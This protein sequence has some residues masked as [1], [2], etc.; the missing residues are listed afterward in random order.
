MYKKVKFTGGFAKPS[1]PT[2]VIRFLDILA[3]RGRLG[4]CGYRVVRIPV[5]LATIL[6]LLSVSI[7]RAAV[8]VRKN[9]AALTANENTELVDAFLALKA[10]GK[11]DGYVKTHRENYSAAHTTNPASPNPAFLPWHRQFMKQIQ[12]DIKALPG[13]ATTGNPLNQVILPYSFCYYM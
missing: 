1:S 3:M 10:N 2:V 8:D 7:A 11:Y 4:L 6:S 9:V 13:N 5:V 12:A